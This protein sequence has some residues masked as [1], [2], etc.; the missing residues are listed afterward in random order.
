MQ[1]EA[2]A[3]VTRVREDLSK[4]YKDKLQKQ[5]E[6]FATKRTEL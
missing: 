1:E 3:K 2:D 5:E 4:D 6:R